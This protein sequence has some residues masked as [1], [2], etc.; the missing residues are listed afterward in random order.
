MLFKSVRVIKDKG[1]LDLFQ[2]EKEAKEIGQGDATV[3]LA[4]SGRNAET[5]LSWVGD[6]N[7]HKC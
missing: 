2:T 5:D 7:G 1:R 4:S 3:T 6:K